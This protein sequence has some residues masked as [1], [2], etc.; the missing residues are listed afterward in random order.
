LSGRNIKLGVAA[1]VAGLSLLA[2]GLLFGG[3]LVSAQEPTPQATEEAAPSTPQ[4]AP[5]DTA[6][7]DDGARPNKAECDKDGDG[8]PDGAADGDTTGG[9]RFRGGT[10]GMAQ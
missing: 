1:G 5:Q 2:G 8:Q 4:T 9:V 7:S 6:P 10:R 3:T